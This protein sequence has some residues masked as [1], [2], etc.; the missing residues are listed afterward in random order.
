MSLPGSAHGCIGNPCIICFPKQDVSS[1]LGEM[2]KR[3]E[4]ERDAWKG[5]LE[6]LVPFLSHRDLCHI[7]ELSP[8]CNCGYKEALA[9]FAKFKGSR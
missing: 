1:Q 7:W 2:V 3:I 9:A 5:Q 4:D 8:Y 6:D